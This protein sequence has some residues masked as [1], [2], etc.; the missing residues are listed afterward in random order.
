[1]KSSA[2]RDEQKRW[3]KCCT[4]LNI[5]ILE[6]TWFQDKSKAHRESECGGR[7]KGKITKEELKELQFWELERPSE[8]MF[9]SLR[10]T[11]A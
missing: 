11:I 7:I 1:M 4:V 2:Q 8:C 10:L 9:K 3:H 5:D 6:E